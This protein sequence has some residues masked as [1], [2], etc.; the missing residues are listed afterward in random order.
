MSKMTQGFVTVTLNGEEKTL[1]PTLKAIQ[2]LSRIHGGL[3][4]IRDGLV[5]QN[6]DVIVSV[7]RYGL[8][9]DDRGAK[10]LPE[11]VFRNGLDGELIM[12]LIKFVGILGNGGREIE[13]PVA[14]AEAGEGDAAEGN[15]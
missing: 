12:P 13:E 7:L 15:A 6:I 10:S 11:K 9:L 8:D 1:K 14:A 4:G 3:G 2:A 5:Q